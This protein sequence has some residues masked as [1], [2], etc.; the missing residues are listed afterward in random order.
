MV[1][2]AGGEAKP[3]LADERGAAQPAWTPDNR[4]LVFISARA[5]ALNLWEIDIASRQL[6]QITTGPGNDF[7]P[8]V[9][10]N[11]RISYTQFSHQVDLYWAPLERGQERHTRLTAHSLDN[12]GARVSPDGRKILYHSSRTGNFELW[13]LDRESGNERQLTEDP[14]M[15]AMGD[16]SPDGRQV[17][18]ASLRDGVARLWV[19]DVESGRARRLSEKVLGVPDTHFSGPRWSPDGKVIGFIAPGPQ[20]D[21]LWTVDPDGQNLRAAVSGVLGFDWYR[22]SRR[23]IYYRKNDS[24]QTEMRA[25]DI[26]SGQETVLL[27]APVAELVVSADGRAVAYVHA[28][29]HFDM[30]L[31]LLLLD[32]GALPRVSGPPRKLTNGEGHWH[33]HNGGWSPDGKALVY[34]RDTDSGDVYMIENYR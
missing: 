34:T 18:F 11:G 3:L 17:V 29:S 28:A 33:V 14:A 24:G 12:F 21:A 19:L 13:V 1:P 10:R 27:R 25:A 22:E 9:A 7:M 5:G 16:W 20:G 4:R 26:V 6:R 32:P 30:Q 2:A 23:V 15:D 31:H 8:V